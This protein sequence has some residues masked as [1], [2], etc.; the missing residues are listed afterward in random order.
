MVVVRVWPRHPALIGPELIRSWRGL[1]GARSERDRID[2]WAARMQ[3]DGLRWT[4]VAGESGDREFWIGVVLAADG[5]K[6]ARVVVGHVVARIREGRCPAIAATAGRQNGALE[7]GGAIKVEDRAAEG[8]Q[9]ARKRAVG[10]AQHAVG[11]V[12]CA[13]HAG[14][15]DG[16]A[17]AAAGLVGRKRAVDDRHVTLVK[18]GATRAEA[19][20]A[21][22]VAGRTAGSLIGRKRAVA[23]G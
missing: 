22:A 3:R 9:I 17:F 14:S 20:R 5:T 1:V 10:D 18:D 12:D 8:R 23:N 19:A 2:R 21:V 15:A 7:T 6:T 16:D 13:T 11:I 4:T